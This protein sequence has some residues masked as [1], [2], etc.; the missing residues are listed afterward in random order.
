MDLSLIL[1]ILLISG[2]IS[3]LVAK[4]KGLPFGK[5]F[6]FGFVL[7]PF[8]MLAGLIG[9]IATKKR[10]IYADTIKCGQCG[11]EIKEGMKTC[12][13]CDAQVRSPMVPALIFA[14]VFIVLG[15]LILLSM[16]KGKQASLQMNQPLF[17]SIQAR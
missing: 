15:S 17:K 2:A 16:S 12:P 1:I 10:V 7:G 3:G 6:F 5:W 13:K 9:S 8:I 4:D 11:A 14:L